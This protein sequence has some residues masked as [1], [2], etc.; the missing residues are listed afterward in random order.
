MGCDP[1]MKEIIFKKLLKDLPKALDGLLS[2]FLDEE[3]KKK[4]KNG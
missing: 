2:L 4:K 1:L 3:T